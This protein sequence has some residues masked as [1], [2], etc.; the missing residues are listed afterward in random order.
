VSSYEYIADWLVEKLD[1]KRDLIKPEA[2][3]TDLGIDS[4]SVVELVFDL[5]DKYEI[6]VPEEKVDFS[7][8]GQ[9]AAMVDEL[10]QAKG[11]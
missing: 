4:L 11:G 3:L 9:A 8:L 2:T 5:E 1:V 10:V 6:E 7:T